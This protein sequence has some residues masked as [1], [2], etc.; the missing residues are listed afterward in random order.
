MMVW[1]LAM[2]ALILKYCFRPDATLHGLSD[3]ASLHALTRC[4]ALC[5]AALLLLQEVLSVGGHLVHLSLGLQQSQ[6][7][8]SADHRSGFVSSEVGRHGKEPGTG[9]VRIVIERSHEHLV[10]CFLHAFNEV[11]A[12]TIEDFFPLKILRISSHWKY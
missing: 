12:R 3:A 10:R 5:L 4:V 8:L 2:L 7:L 9:I 11:R 1:R 6:V